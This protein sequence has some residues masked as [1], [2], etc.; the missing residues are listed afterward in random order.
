MKECVLSTYV[1]PKVPLLDILSQGELFF[2][3]QKSLKRI[4]SY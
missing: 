4:I 3:F 1:P 2:F